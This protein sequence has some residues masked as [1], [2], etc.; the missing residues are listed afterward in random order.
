MNLKRITRATIGT[1]VFV[2]AALGYFYSSYW[3]LFTM[4]VGLN[5]IQFAFTGWCL[6]EKILKSSG[7]KE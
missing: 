2:S 7:V 4:F 1:F 6:L 5:M 3:L